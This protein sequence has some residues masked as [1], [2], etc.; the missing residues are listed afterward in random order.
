MK[1]I[2]PV[3]FILLVTG[4]NYVAKP[5]SGD[6]PATVDPTAPAGEIAASYSGADISVAFY[7][8]TNH[9]T[10]FGTLQAPTPCHEVKVDSIVAES[11]PEQVSLNIKTE[12]SGQVCTQVITPK[13]FSGTINVSKDAKFTISYNNKILEQD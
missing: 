4:C 6:K 1:K 11:Y 2:L 8:E 13:K 7:N 12:D 9:F 3:L 10:Y 5:D